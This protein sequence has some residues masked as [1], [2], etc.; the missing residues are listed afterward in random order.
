MSLYALACKNTYGQVSTDVGYS[1]S[2][3]VGK[4]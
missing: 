2:L 4:K 1:Q 3:Q